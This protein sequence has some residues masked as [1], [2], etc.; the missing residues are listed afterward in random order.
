MKTAVLGR[1]S[2]ALRSGYAL[3]EAGH[4]IALVAT[5]KPA[6]YYDAGPDD[7]RALATEAGASFMLAPALGSPEVIARL[8][9]LGADAAVSVNWPSLIG[10]P[11]IRA[12]RHG[13]LN[14][15]AGDLPRYRGNACPNW[16]ILNGETRVGVCI[17]QMQPE[18]VDSGPVLLRDHLA[19]TSDTYIGDV[20]TWLERRI[21]AMFVRAINGLE[22]GTLRPESTPIDP[23]LG[24]RCYPRRPEDSRIDWRQPV[25]RVHRLVRASSR[26][27]GGA[28]SLLEGERR[29]TIWRAAIYQHPGSF[30]AVPGQILK[31]IEGDPV[32]ACGDGCLR[33]TEV[34]LEGERDPETAR[35]M[36]GESL[37]RRLI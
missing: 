24:L 36:V 13:I 23:A 1:S 4:Q 18:E 17:H 7:F 29:V 15:H 10:E 12:F 28:Y 20:V 16:A 22:D 31:R 30:L 27:F 33:L 21:P 6:E 19:L 8:S 35:R 34:T 32:I 11:A 9:S 25:D 37:R 14:A 26:P 2:L 3:L 5:A